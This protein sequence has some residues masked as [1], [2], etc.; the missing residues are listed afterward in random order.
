MG[1]FDGILICSDWD[2]TLRTKY[3]IPKNNIEAINYFQQNGGLF[4]ICSGR[5]LDYLLDFFDEIR[6]NTYVLT[7]NGAIIKH[8]DTDEVLFEGFVDKS[9]EIIV[10][11]LMD[12]G[13]SFK[14][15]S[16]HRK[17]DNTVIRESITTLEE[18]KKLFDSY[19]IYKVVFITEEPEETLEAKKLITDAESL[20]YAAES[21][22]ETSIEILK[23]ENTKGFAVRKLKEHLGAKVLI[24][25]GDYEN[26][27]SMLKSADI[28][29][30]VG[31]AIPKV[32]ECADRITVPCAD[33]AMASIIEDLEKTVVLP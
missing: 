25:A 16:V 31:D 22:W 2:G 15:I 7:L 18:Y 20:G 13:I 3:G 29:Y 9:A 10:K 28:S 12:S 30:A 11:R 4:T 8:P 5:P 27:I 26:D 23:L 19:K 14:Y 21:S 24:T 1:K 17:S 33:G 32:K 6:P